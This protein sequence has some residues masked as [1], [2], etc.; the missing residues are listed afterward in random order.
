MDLYNIYY[1]GMKINNR[2]LLENDINEIKTKK[3][4]YKRD[5]IT[6]KLNK[7]SVNELQ[8]VKTILI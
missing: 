4:I 5:T 7:I 8:Y 3:E 1:K 6:D 2:P